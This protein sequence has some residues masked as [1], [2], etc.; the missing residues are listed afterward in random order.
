M[1]FMMALL[2]AMGTA[3]GKVRLPHLLS[4]GM[5]LQQQSDAH[6]WGW[7]KPGA[8]VQATISTT[9]ITTTAKADPKGNFK[10]SVKTPAASYAPF[11]IMLNDGDGE[12]S[13]N[14]VLSGEVWVC[15]GQSNMEMPMAGFWNC[16]VEGYNEEVVNA[17]QYPGIHYVKIPSVMSMTPLG[18]THCKWETI[19]PHTVGDCSAAGYF[20]AQ[21][22]NR[23]LDV[24]VGLI[25][26]NKGGTRVESWLDY[27][28]LKRHTT[29][30]LDS[31]ENVK[32]FNWDFHRPLV[33]GN[34]TFHPILNYSIKGILF[35][36]GCSNVGDPGDKYSTNLKLLVEQWR[37]GFNQGEVPFYFV[38]IAPYE[39][40]DVNG[41]WGPKLR[42]QQFKASEIIPNSAIVCTEDLVYP[43]ETKQIHPAQKRQVGQRLAYLALNRDYGMKE[44]RCYSPAF[45]EM[46]ISNDTCYVTIQNDYQALNRSEGLEG[47]E[48]AGADKVF[49][50][51]CASFGPRGIAVTSP[52]VKQP[53]AVRY[54]FRNFQLGNVSNAAGLPLFPFRTDDW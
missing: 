28:N 48:V 16:P 1:I 23:A 10:L 50:K 14:N 19:S 22:V 49:H 38:Q 52:E 54:C 37:R 7:A 29:E 25:L 44:M 27:D 13:I 47:F 24:P 4:D 2:L 39:N 46:S 33:W 43:Y 40:N 35:Y 6:L 18:D 36:Q 41:D 34:V 45:K 21:V 12:V 3:Q 15:A 11:S 5:I 8:M 17:R 30:S 31:M 42:E 32:K 51:A 9:G 26:A 20:F 53:V